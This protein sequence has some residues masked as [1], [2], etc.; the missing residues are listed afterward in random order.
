VC[1]IKDTLNNLIM[2]ALFTISPEAQREIQDA[3]RNQ[4][5]VDLSLEKEEEL[6]ISVEKPRF[7][8]SKHR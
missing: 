8:V 2:L 1:N 4:R 6:H 7:K 5:K 3:S